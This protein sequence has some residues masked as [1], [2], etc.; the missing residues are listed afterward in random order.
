MIVNLPIFLHF[1]DFHI[2]I[3]TWIVFYPSPFP[4]FQTDSRDSARVLGLDDDY[5]SRVEEQRQQREEIRRRRDRNDRS[6]G[7]GGG[8]R[9]SANQAP[10]RESVVH[11]IFH[12]DIEFWKLEMTWSLWL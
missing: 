1:L 4:L 11:F 9:E 6:E 8:A 2:S 12:H 3:F 7:G 10:S 5:L